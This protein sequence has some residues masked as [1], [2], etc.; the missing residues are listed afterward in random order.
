MILCI[1]QL[2]CRTPLILPHRGN[3]IASVLP[4]SRGTP[5]SRT[6]TNPPSI[7]DSQGAST[8]LQNIG[9]VMSAFA[10]RDSERASSACRC[11]HLK[12]YLRGR[13]D[14]GDTYHSN[15]SRTGTCRC[16]MRRTICCTT[17]YFGRQASPVDIMR[18]I[19]PSFQQLALIEI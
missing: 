4:R 2:T 10:N 12:Q 14:R 17:S 16:C 6:V 13:R 7:G 1:Y 18:P 11:T 19:Q 5:M 15:R 8:H 9:R 3:L